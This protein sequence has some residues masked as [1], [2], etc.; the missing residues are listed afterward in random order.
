M[1]VYLVGGAVRDELLGRPVAERD[2]VVVGATPRE[3]LDA[4]LPPGRPRF[5]GVPAP[6]HP[7]GARA[8]AHRAQDR[9]R[10]SRLRAA[11]LARRHARRRPAPPRPHHQ[12]DG[13][14]RRRHA[15]RSLTA[16]ARD[17]EARSLR[18]VSDGV[19]RGSGAH[20]ARRALPRALR[21]RSASRSRPR[22]CARMRAMVAAGE[23]D[24]LVPERVWQE[25]VRALGEPAPEAW[26]RGA[27]RLRRARAHLPGA[28]RAVRRAAAAAVA[29]GD[30]HR[31]A[32]RARAAGRGRR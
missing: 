20:P 6:G 2:W 4:R 11:L 32:H 18:H 28:R 27:A 23:A 29:S 3:M 25:T 13:A 9:S 1:K 31:P 21:S 5:P 7:R 24:A 15:D 30:R 8:R 16:A 10:L 12:R 14:R 19:R 22:R 17:L 26:L